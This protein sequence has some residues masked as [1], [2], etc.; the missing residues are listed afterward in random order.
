MHRAV[1]RVS[2]GSLD[3]PVSLAERRAERA[4][5]GR[6]WSPRDALVSLLREIDKEGVKPENIVIAYNER[7]DDGATST[8]FRAAGPGGGL[9][10]LGILERVKTKIQTN[11]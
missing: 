5:D 1:P 11:G 10:A 6:E 9:V 8:H 7:H 4:W 2:D 3:I